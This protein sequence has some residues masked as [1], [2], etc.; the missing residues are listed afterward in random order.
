MI[1]PRLP[2]RAAC[3]TLLFAL[4]G[5]ALAQDLEVSGSSEKSVRIVRTETPP[6]IDGVLDEAAWSSAATIEDLHQIQPVEYAEASEPTLIRLMYDDDALYIGARLYDS[7]PE[8]ITARILRQ[9]AEVFADDWFA[10]TLDPFHDRRSGYL[11]QTNPNGLRQEALYQNVS[12]EQWDWQGIWY[13]AAGIDGEGWIAEMAIPFKTLSFDPLNDTWG[14]NFRRSIARRDE[15]IGW[16]SR[17]RATNPSVSGIAI[18]FEGLDQGLGL[19]VVP[20][21][22]LRDSRDRLSDVD[23][24]ESAPSLDLFY[25]ITPSLTGSLTLNTDFSATEVD[26]RQVNLTRFALFFPEKRDFF[27]QDADI[28]EFGGIGEN[29]RP[30]FSRRIG[31]AADGEIVDIDA[32]AKISG[33]VGRFNLGMLSIRQEASTDAPAE[34]ST[35]ARVSAN[36]LSESTVGLIATH[37][38][39]QSP[40]DNSLVGADFMYRN[41]RLP[42]GRVLEGEAWVQ[43][44]RTE[45]IDGDDRAYGLRVRS[46][47]E[48]GFRGGVGFTELDENFNPALGFANR[49]G[50]RR[51]D[52]DLGYT[53]R[54]R[55]GFLRAVGGGF[56]AE[57]IE[58]LAGGLESQEI[59][60][61]LLE[62]EG[63]R[64]DNV[65]VERSF[66]KE[67]LLEPFDIH[68]GVVIPA[69]EYSFASTRVNFEF[70]DQR[71]LSGEIG[72]Q[73]G[74]FFSGDR[75]EIFGAIRWRPSGHFTGRLEYGVNEIDLPE[76][77]FTTRLLSVRADI[78]FS[79]RLSWVNLIQYDNVSEVIGIN[80][81]LHWI[82][83]AGREA[84]LVLNHSA[85]DLDRDD[86]F[87]SSF[88]EAAVK[89]NYT[90]RF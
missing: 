14:I 86:R 24:S 30:F 8:Q 56:E 78:V 77:T 82:P 15:R 51:L 53:H 4:G 6:V 23:D 41:T 48:T 39:P 43:Q 89:F 50:I 28:F 81:R 75:D 22:A 88:S 73:T 52:G 65:R 44:S 71:K 37:G 25:K 31:L 64:G 3:A 17:N 11:F 21:I 35:V 76:G 10:V 40:L 20:A 9:G 54:P 74:G 80:S 32:G 68:P 59:E 29:G 33:R 18:G 45:G 19:D 79:A 7:E 1:E 16:V 47:N 83:E 26:D 58:R 62:A 84:Y 46:P 87:H 69:G 42:G 66:N 5:D 2:P 85:E 57:R 55:S 90:F 12:E 49:V 61:E 27:L 34:T 38:S 13:A 36:V 67:V 72:Y 63:R 70:A 60:L